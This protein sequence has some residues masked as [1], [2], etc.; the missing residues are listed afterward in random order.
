MTYMLGP[1][2]AA[3]EKSE[4]GRAEKMEEFGFQQTEY[5]MDTEVV[6]D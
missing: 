6:N 2:P 3:A 4:G 1:G 5:A